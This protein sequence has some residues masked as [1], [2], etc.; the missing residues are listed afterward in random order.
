MSCRCRQQQHRRRQRAIKSREHF[1]GSE[2]LWTLVVCGIRGI[3]LKW[4]FYNH[5]VTFDYGEVIR[6]HRS[7]D[8]FEDLKLPYKDQSPTVSRTPERYKF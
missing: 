1:Q 5:S 7:L 8:T 4:V 3:R 6:H 2:R